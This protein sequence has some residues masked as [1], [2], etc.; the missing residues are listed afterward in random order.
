MKQLAVM[1]LLSVITLQEYQCLQLDNKVNTDS[2]Q[3]STE[4]VAEK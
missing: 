1:L 3:K 2:K 4:S